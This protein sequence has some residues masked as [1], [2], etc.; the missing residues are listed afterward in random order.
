MLSLRSSARATA[1]TISSS[2]GRRASAAGST[3]NRRSSALV[4]G[5]IDA[6]RSSPRRRSQSAPKSSAKWRTIR[7]LVNVTQPRGEVANSSA[8]RPGASGGRRLS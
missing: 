8:A 5:P 7:G 4:T 2:E 6:A 1:A 3:P